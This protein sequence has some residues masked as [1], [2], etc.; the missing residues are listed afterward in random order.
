MVKTGE[1]PPIIPEKTAGKGRIGQSRNPCGGNP[2][3]HVR[4]PQVGSLNTCKY[5]LAGTVSIA[6]PGHISVSAGVLV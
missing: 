6:V 2:W 1:S 3:H 4:M 5:E